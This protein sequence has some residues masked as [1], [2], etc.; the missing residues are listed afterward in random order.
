MAR[1]HKGGSGRPPV[2]VTLSAPSGGVAGVDVGHR[3]IR[4]AVADRTGTVLA[5]DLAS[6][7]VDAHGVRGA[8]PGGPRWSA[9]PP[10]GG[11]SRA[12]LQAIG[13]CVPAPLDRRSAQISTGI[14]P[15]WRDLSPPWSWSG[16]S[17]YRCSPTT[18]PTSAPSPSSTTVPPAAWRPRLPEGR[19]RPRCRDRARRPAAPGATG[20]AGRDRARPDP[21]GR[22]RLPLRQP[23]LP[24][25]DRG[26]RRICSSCSNRRTTSRS[27]PTVCSRSTPTVTPAYAVCSATPARRSAGPW[28]TSATASTPSWSSSA[29]RSGT[30]ASLL[31]GACLDRPLR[32]AHTA[33]AVRVRPP[34]SATTPSSPARSRSPSLGSR[35]PDAHS[36]SSSHVGL[37]MPA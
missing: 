37:W 36:W 34:S 30:S 8:R 13:M 5:E 4:V 26:A 14:L 12:D 21:R 15:G 19:Q 9:R 10:P 17:A 32:P 7:D 25:D 3:H 22:P 28:P 2:L 24:R 11:L 27:T 33:A 23:R 16:G 35:R 20:I 1:P 6:V 31:A 29:A 18:T